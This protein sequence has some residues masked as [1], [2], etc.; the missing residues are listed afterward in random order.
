MFAFSRPGRCRSVWVLASAAFLAAG[1]R[2]E[3]TDVSAPAVTVQAEH[4]SVGPITEVVDADAILS[5][6]AQAS[7]AARVSAPIRAEYVQRGS[8]VHKGQLLIA[9]DSRDLAGQVMDSKGTLTTAQAAY[10]A[11]VDATNPDQVKQAETD[12]ASAKAAMEVA[13]RTARDR[14]RLFHEGALPGREADAAQAAAVQAQ[15]TYAAAEQRLNSTL[16]TTRETN[17]ESAQGQLTSARGR[18]DAAQAQLSFAQL[19]SPIDGVV[20]DRPFFPGDTAAAGTPVITVM[21]TSHLIAKLHMAQATAQQLHLGGAA[22]VTVPGVNAPVQATVSLISP[23][24]DPG[25]TTVEVWLSLANPDGR[26]NVGTP[27]HAAIHARTVQDAVQVPATA[28]VPANEG[29]TAVMIIGPDGKAHKQ[30]VKV[31][32]RTADAVQITDGVSPANDVIVNGGYGL[33]DGTP[34]KVGAPGAQDDS[35]KDSGKDGDKD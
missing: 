17:R 13:Q 21:D 11:A 14:E 24:L 32:I 9:L 7:I 16:G 4:P 25:S 15:A 29:G 20:T 2:K 18:Y 6:A 26:F 8:R 31:G 1:C 3:A 23:A 19:R 22:D 10:T 27:V 33:D 30:P 34:V 12:V 28:I 5:P 35:G